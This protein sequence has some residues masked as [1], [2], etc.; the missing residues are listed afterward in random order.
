MLG[1]VQLLWDSYALL[2]ILPVRSQW[3]HYCPDT[4]Q[5][6]YLDFRQGLMPLILGAS[7]SKTSHWKL[8]LKFL[9]LAMRWFCFSARAIFNVPASVCRWHI[10]PFSFGVRICGCHHNPC[11]CGVPACEGRNASYQIDH[12]KGGHI[13]GGNPRTEF[14]QLLSASM[15]SFVRNQNTDLF[16]ARVTLQDPTAFLA[17]GNWHLFVVLHLHTIPIRP[18]NQRAK[19]DKGQGAFNTS[20]C[21]VVL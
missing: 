8:V 18:A 21:L 3:G 10:G 15:V 9:L 16:R 1:Y 6:L 2:I 5:C 13:R 20:L 17:L 7:W 4:W 19:L 14:A 12:P 11:K